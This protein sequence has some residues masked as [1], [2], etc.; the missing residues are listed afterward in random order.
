MEYKNISKFN[1]R[2]CISGK[3]M[4]INRLTGNIFRKYLA[5]FKIT[6]SQLTLLFILTKRGGLTQKQL[7]DF[8]FLEKSTLN[9]NLQRLIDKQYITRINF[10]VIEITNKGK[11]FVENI[12]PEWEKAMAEIRGIIGNQGEEAINTIHKSLTKK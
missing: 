3:I 5:P 10:P 7:S 1:P 2:E 11:K 12:I 6:D 4:R 9:R 8:I